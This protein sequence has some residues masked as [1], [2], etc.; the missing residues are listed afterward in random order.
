MTNKRI[1]NDFIQDV[2]ARSDIVEVIQARVSLKKRGNNYLACCPFHQEKTASFSVS[3]EKQFYYCFGCQASGNVI[4]FLM[5]Y[6]R[7]DFIEALS[8]LAA[9]QGLELPQQQDDSQQENYR[10]LYAV[11]E[12]V[13]LHYQQQLRVSQP[14]INYLK[15]RGLIGKTAKEYG[16]GFANNSW[17]GLL[18]HLP[19]KQQSLT[20]NGLL[21]HKD[22]QK[23]FD[24]FRNRI[25]FPIRDLRGRVIAF[26][27]R[28]IGDDMPKYM[29]SPETP[30]FH[31]GREVYG[32][33]EARKH[34]KHLD[35][36]VV[37]EGYMDVISLYQHGIPYA[38][39]TLGTAISQ[40]HIQKIL[41][42]TNHLVFCFDGDR[43]GRAAAWKALTISLPILR[44]GISLKFLFLPEGEDPDS[45]VKQQGQ[46]AFEQLVTQAAPLA[47]V[48]FD[49]LQQ[50]IPIDSVSSRAQ[51]AKQASDHLNT[52][53]PGI[54][55]SLLY[56]RL[57]EIL[58]I[59]RQDLEQLITARRQGPSADTT[60]AD[61]S[62]PRSLSPSVQKTLS[63]LV[64]HPTLAKCIQN[65][66][67]W[68]HYQF[69]GKTTLLTLL[70]LLHQHPT[71]TTGQLL[72]QIGDPQ[73]QQHIAKL[74]AVPLAIPV[75]GYQD[76]FLGAI[77]QIKNQCNQEVV[78][79]LIRKAHSNPLSDA[80]KTQL[81]ELLAQKAQESS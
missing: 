65:L 51:F 56:D 67:E 68:Q 73:R 4:S 30:I 11:L 14:A 27:G 18:Q 63:L 75:D 10:A 45:L 69:H 66:D 24:R 32:L 71:L 79:K 49:Q 81:Q 46:Q 50:D 61:D 54:F 3:Q 23:T 38:V 47:D 6:D 44:D 40:T 43:A 33:Y 7:M 64:Q 70:K 17:D 19:N 55:Q 60:A 20:T 58:H 76:E 28:S 29:N 13:T 80:E 15:S 25:M 62:R 53:P 35:H 12:E 26:G 72:Q 36:L 39:A 8:Y 34:C 16:I 77:R 9:Q 59:A 2:V 1:P 52:M 48:F 57:A 5:A 31:K 21:I 42:Y 22:N 41:R 78:D 37:V 74:A